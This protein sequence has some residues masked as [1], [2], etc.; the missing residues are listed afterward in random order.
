LI[1]ATEKERKLTVDILVEAF[2][3]LED[4]N[5]INYIVGTGEKRLGRM[6]VLMGYLFDKALR[7][8]AVY[9]SDNLGCCLLIT[10]ADKDGFSAQKVLSSLRLLFK[11]IGLAKLPKVLKRQRIIERNYPNGKYIRPMIFAVKQEY[12]GTVTAAKLIMQVYREN[13][14]LRLPIIVDTA[15]KDLVRLYQKFGLE[16]FNVEKELGFPIYL[17]RMYEVPDL[18]N[19][20]KSSKTEHNERRIQV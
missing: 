17:L 7:S 14:N 4:D 11:C 19:G 9:L 20:R 2:M 13:K 12:Q 6:Q 1:K 5:S 3:P 10:H 18:E 8:G 16:I 15:S